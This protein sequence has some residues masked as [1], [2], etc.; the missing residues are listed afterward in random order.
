LLLPNDLSISCGPSGS[1]PH[2]PTLPLFG[3]MEV[4]ARTELW[5][6]PACRLHARVRQQPIRDLR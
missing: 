2:K 4:G 6:A 5:P 3:L 1:R